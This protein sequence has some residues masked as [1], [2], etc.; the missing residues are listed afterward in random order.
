VRTACSWPEDSEWGR[1]T[2]LALVQ[3]ECA[4]VQELLAGIKAQEIPGDLVEFG[5]FEGWWIDFLWNI[6][7][8]IGLKRRVYGFDSFEGLSEPDPKHDL[9]FWKKGQCA[10]SLEE[11]QKNVQGLARPR[12]K[13]VK[14]LFEK[15]L[16]GADAVLAEQFCYVLIDCDMFQPALHCLRYLGPRLAD[17][18]ILVFDDWPHL[19]GFEEQ[20]AFEKWLPEVPHLEFEF[21]FYGAIGHFYIRVQYK[22]KLEK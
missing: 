20:R 6:T 18:A 2:H 21:P 4:Y 8:N 13:L 17:G 16:R 5:R 10:C 19:R 15:S 14:G 9:D 22:T 7:E 11:V 3:V 1:R 12:I